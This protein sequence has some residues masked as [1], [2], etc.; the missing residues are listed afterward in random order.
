MSV[1]VRRAIESDRPRILEISSQI[2]DG[3]DYVPELLD[4]WFADLE[5]ELVVATIDAQVIAFAHRTWLSPGIAWFE[6]IRTDPVFQGRGAGKVITEYLIRAAR[7]D[8]ASLIELSTYIDNEASIYIIESY[9]FHL[10]GT[11]SY[12]ERPVELELP[13]SVGDP[14]CIHPLS[15]QETIEFVG[16]SEFLSLAR[17]RFP[18]GWRFF[19]F[20]HDPCEA[21]ARLRC[22]LGFREENELK[23]VLCIRQSPDHEGWITINFLDGTPA[24]TRA[25]LNHALHLY[26]G[27][28][29]EVMVPVHQGQHAAALELL[30]EAGFKSWSEFKADVFVYEMLL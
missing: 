2:W 18:R 10:V 12:L 30:R 14:S 16:H 6:G 28:T 4:G 23:A 25:L 21:M 13:E 24:A 20:D 8:G 7:E 5:G 3:E 1:C 9:G 11:F 22:R 27:K 26:E 17:R 15:E 19:P 29:F